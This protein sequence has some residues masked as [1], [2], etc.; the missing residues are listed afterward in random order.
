M[1]K[2]KTECSKTTTKTIQRKTKSYLTMSLMKNLRRKTI[3]PTWSRSC[4]I[5]TRNQPSQSRE[6]LKTLQLSLR[7]C[8]RSL[9]RRKINLTRQS[10]ITTR[11]KPSSMPKSL[12]LRM[13]TKNSRLS[14]K[15]TRISKRSKK[16]SLKSSRKMNRKSL[17]NKRRLLSSDREMFQ[18]PIHHQ[19]ETG[20]K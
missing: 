12:W 18:S 3:V 7:L 9:T 5:T 19:K 17:L 8:R 11:S 20:K 4:S 15:N 1:S 2:V 6:K 16:S 13:Q 10:S 14:R